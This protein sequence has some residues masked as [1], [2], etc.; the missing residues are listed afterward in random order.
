MEGDVQVVAGEGQVRVGRIRLF[1]RDETERLPEFAGRVEVGRRHAVLGEIAAQRAVFRAARYRR[2]SARF[3]HDDA[4]AGRVAKA[5]LV[6]DVF[7]G[8]AH[9][10]RRCRAL[11]A[12]SACCRDAGVHERERRRRE[13]SLMQAEEQAAVG[14]HSVRMCPRV[15]RLRL[16]EA[17]ALVE[18]HRLAD[19]GGLRG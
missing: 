19:I 1:G 9:V 12:R 16:R 14:E 7:A 17:E 13:T 8:V 6:E 3:Q 4:L 5:D 11:R 15:V 2:I 10:E 18:L